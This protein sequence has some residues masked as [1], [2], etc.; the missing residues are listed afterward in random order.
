MA[1]RNEL[2]NQ[3]IGLISVIGILVTLILVVRWVWSAFSALPD[4]IAIS[5]ITAAATVITST[6]AVVLAR[7]LQRKR[8]LEAQHIESKIPI[9]EDF[10]RQL[11]AIFYSESGEKDG[12]SNINSST[13]DNDEIVKFLRKWHVQLILWGGP[14]VIIAYD[15]WRNELSATP[16]SPKASAVWSTVDLLFAIRRELGH[17]DKKVERITFVSLILQNPKLFMEMYQEN[18][19]ITLAEIAEVEAKILKK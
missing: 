2:R 10:I 7:Y 1:D 13:V 17:N 15:R 14:E 12:E 11:F 16:N 4:T 9:Y 5:I 3:V 19:N 6:V 18:S 8:E